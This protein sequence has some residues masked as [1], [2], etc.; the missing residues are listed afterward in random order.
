MTFIILASANNRYK[1]LGILFLV[2]TLFSTILLSL[3]ACHHAA[4]VVLSVTTTKYNK[5]ELYLLPWLL[6]YNNTD[7][8]T[9]DYQAATSLP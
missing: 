2:P 5:M 4:V 1:L 8:L 7:G 6:V 3:V 9:H